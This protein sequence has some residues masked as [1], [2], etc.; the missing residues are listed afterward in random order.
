MPSQKLPTRVTSSSSLLEPF[1]HGVSV[2]ETYSESVSTD[3]LSPV[4]VTEDNAQVKLSLW[5]QWTLAKFVFR[6]CGKNSQGRGKQ[7]SIKL[8]LQEQGSI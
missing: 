3:V 1:E 2:T 5:I 8:L 6:I 4:L 7:I